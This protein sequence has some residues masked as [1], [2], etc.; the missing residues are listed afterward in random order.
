MRHRVHSF[1]PHTIL[2]YIIYEFPHC[3]VLCFVADPYARRVND[4]RP[5]ITRQRHGESI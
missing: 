1:T 2:Y 5:G 4:Y 3:G